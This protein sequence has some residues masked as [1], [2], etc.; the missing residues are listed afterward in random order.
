[1]NYEKAKKYAQR[2][3]EH[4]KQWHNLK[5]IW[6]KNDVNKKPWTF[7]KKLTA[8]LIANCLIIEIYA[9]VTMW[10]FMDLS[11]LATLITAVVGEC[12]LMCA[13]VVKATIENKNGGITYDLAMKDRFHSE[14]E[15][16][17][18]DKKDAVG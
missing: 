3:A 4:V 16:T 18:Q 13:Y 12:I 7:T 2:H 8:F 1:M 17:E 5:K 10:H 11:A 6:Q 9:L 15:I 14:N